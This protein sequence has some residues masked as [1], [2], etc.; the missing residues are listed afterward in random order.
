MFASV[1][2]KDYVIELDGKPEI[3]KRERW[4]GVVNRQNGIVTD[5]EYYFEGAVFD[6]DEKTDSYSMG[7]TV[8]KSRV[9][10]DEQAERVVFFK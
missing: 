1:E 6:Y 3:I 9:E 2:V 4:L 10:F 8:K 5:A 7:G